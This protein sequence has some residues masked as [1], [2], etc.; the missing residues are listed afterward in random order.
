[1]TS[2]LLS[3]PLS[4]RADVESA[5]NAILS[6]LDRHL[7]PGHARVSI[8]HTAAH[9]D[10]IAVQLEGYARR[11]WGAAP[12]GVESDSID[13]SS[14]RTGLANG[15]N[16]SHP[17][18]WG[19][20]AKD[21]P[22]QRLMAPIGFAIALIPDKIWYPLSNAAKRNVETWLLQIN[23]CVLVNLGLARVG[24][25]HS[26]DAMHD[27]LDKAEEWYLGDG[28]YSDGVRAQR[29]YYVTF[30]I[31]YYCLIYAQI[32]STIP[33]L[34]DSE[35]A[36]RYRT[37]AAQIAPDILHYFDPDTG[38]CIPFGRSLTY[39]FACAAFWGAMVFAEVGSNHPESANTVST[40]VAKGVWLR[41][42]KW[43]FQRPEIFN[44][45]GTLSIGWAYPN[46]MMA[47]SYNSPGSPYWALKAFLPL[48]LP[49]GHPFWS[50]DDTPAAPPPKLP[51]PHPVPHAY[52][53]FIHSRRSPSHTYVL[54]S[55]QAATFASM[56]HSG[57]KYSKLSYSATF[58]F[59]VPVGAYGL[60]QIVPDCTLA[61]SD[62]VDVKDG[63]GCHWRVRRVAK[64]AKLIRGSPSLEP[65]GHGKERLQVGMVATWDAWKDVDVK[66]WIIPMPA[67]EASFEGDWHLR[68]HRIVTG[69]TI[70]TCDGG[71]SVSGVKSDGS[72]RRLVAWDD[73]LDE[74]V[75]SSQSSETTS[76]SALVRSIDG[77]TGIRAIR[78]SPKPT[79][80]ALDA[81]GQLPV[82][83]RIINCAPDSNIMFPKSLLPTLN[84]ELS[85]RAEPHWL[86][87]GVFAVAGHSADD[88]S[89]RR[90]WEEE[91][92]IPD[93]LRQVLK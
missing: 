83:A 23:E 75:L 18:F 66:T 80:A 2:S 3:N 89:W 79:E 9:F 29:D 6:P 34:R 90:A 1:M 54:T 20:P 64:D 7:S 74:G 91:L 11:L 48:V 85:P 71:F 15:T 53:I 32:A 40:A 69:R 42:L 39:R 10:D 56:R 68:V 19:N 41:H 14:Y 57:E 67:G 52:S 50:N 61:L 82:E 88:R 45:D 51:S 62:D 63:N 5:L 92:P 70:W 28:W 38:A 4:T 47:E 93:W 33:E 87:S 77:T 46:L 8:G 22:D 78:W 12:F 55:G 35:R 59:S 36:E 84:T 30:A 58:G 76:S 16:P 24:A 72:R 44:G 27:G 26:L 21:F 73:V 86:I 65:I 13:W 60:E 25:Q 49:Q 31:H 81:T 43:W 17:E 37:R